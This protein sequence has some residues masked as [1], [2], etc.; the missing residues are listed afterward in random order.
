[1]VETTGSEPVPPVCKAE[2]ILTPLT[3]IDAVEKGTPKSEAACELQIDYAAGHIGLP[4]QVIAAMMRS[5]P[6]VVAAG[7]ADGL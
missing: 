1:L 2:I 7:V 3:G 5:S 6:Y 4:A